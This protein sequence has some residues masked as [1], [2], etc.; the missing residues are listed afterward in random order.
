M[1]LDRF[2]EMQKAELLGLIWRACIKGDI[3]YE[4]S[5]SLSQLVDFILLQDL[6]LL[7]RLFSFCR[8]DNRNLYAKVSETEAVG[9]TSARMISY[10]PAGAIHG[11]QNF[12]YKDPDGTNIVELTDYGWYLGL[13]LKKYSQ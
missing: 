9:L 8:E 6:P 1:L 2:V 5:C 12:A 13:I 10:V 4:L 7:Q 11:N 3:T